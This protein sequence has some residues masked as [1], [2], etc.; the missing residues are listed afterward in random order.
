MAEQLPTGNPF[1]SS[2]ENPG[3][4]TRD[5]ECCWGKVLSH[6][7]CCMHLYATATAGMQTH[8]KTMWGGTQETSD[9]IPALEEVI[10]KSVA[11]YPSQMLYSGLSKA[12]NM[13]QSKWLHSHNRS[14]KY[15][16][17][18]SKFNLGS[19]NLRVIMWKKIQI[20]KSLL[21]YQ[22]L[23]WRIKVLE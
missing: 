12:K 7:I 20:Y 19:V 16:I 9:T 10:F 22:V 8:A 6:Y 13:I 18:S 23:S 14:R 5:S 4:N 2:R 3:P 21:Y 17:K 11:F 15:I 1:G